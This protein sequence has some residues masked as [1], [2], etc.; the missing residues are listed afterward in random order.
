[1][2]AFPASSFLRLMQQHR[3]L[4]QLQG[5]LLE[6]ILARERLHRPRHRPPLPSQERGRVNLRCC[7]NLPRRA[8]NYHTNTHHNTRTHIEI[9]VNAQ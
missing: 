6:S 2:L 9:E 5:P 1:M 7:G 8:P 4:S 3:L